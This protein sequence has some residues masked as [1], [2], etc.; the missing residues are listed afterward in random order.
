M[1][2]HP[3]IH[4]SFKCTF[5]TFFST[6]IP[7]I[8]GSIPKYSLN[9]P[10]LLKVGD[11]MEYSRSYTHEDLDK[12]ADLTGDIN[13]I[14]IMKTNSNNEQIK[15]IVHGILTGSMFSTLFGYQIPGTIYLKQNLLFQNIL[16]TD[17]VVTAKVMVT[18]IFYDKHICVVSTECIRDYDK[19]KIIDGTAYI[20]I[21]NLIS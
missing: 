6:Y 11:F 8:K 20:K 9:S 15:T 17:E 13:P 14:H 1:Q 2:L 3:F 5:K 4:N 12:F 16:Y 21:D 18:R 10:V 19:K 7:H